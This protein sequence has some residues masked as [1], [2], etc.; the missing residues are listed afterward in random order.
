MLLAHGAVD[1]LV[2]FL[3]L[4]GSVSIT[5][6]GTA[7]ARARVRSR[8]RVGVRIRVGVRARVVPWPAAP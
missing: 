6:K 1:P 8:L 4:Q 2:E 7:R 5:I 3:V